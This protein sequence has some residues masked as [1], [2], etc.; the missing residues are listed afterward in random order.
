[1][2]IEELIWNGDEK[3]LKSAPEEIGKAFRIDDAPGRYVVFA[4]NSFPNNMTLEGIKLVLDCANGAAYK[5]APIIFRELGA[6]V[7]TIGVNP[8]GKNINTN[9][10]SLNP[11]LLKEK[12]LE[13]RHMQTWVLH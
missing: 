2:E 1:M 8:N 13:T 7:I 9:C 5:V 10:G 12:V 4:K 6:E 11:E 3:L